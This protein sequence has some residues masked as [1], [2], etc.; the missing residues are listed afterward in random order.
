MNKNKLT[1]YSL[2]FAFCVL[3]IVLSFLYELYNISSNGKIVTLDLIDK[4]GC[5][6][7]AYESRSN[8]KRQLNAIYNNDSIKVIVHVS[9]CSVLK[10][11]I[12]CK[13]L[14]SPNQKYCIN[15]YSHYIKL[16]Y[17]LSTINLVILIAIIILYKYRK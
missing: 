3:S 5:F 2:L 6:S 4:K 11:K 16:F 1:F 13:V 12:D 17:V 8:N 15:C 10:N 14:D 7:E 9:E